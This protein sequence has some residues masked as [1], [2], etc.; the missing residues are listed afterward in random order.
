MTAAAPRRQ[1]ET[2]NAIAA[3]DEAATKVLMS[4]QRLA[5][6]A[7]LYDDHNQAQKM[8]LDATARAA[9][10]YAAAAGRNITIF[11]SDR[12]VYVGKRL[13]RANRSV[14]AAANQ[15]K[16]MLARMGVSQITIGHDVPIE[17]LRVLQSRFAQIQKTKGD[18][19][20]PTELSRVRLRVGR[21]PGDYAEFDRLSPDER[22]VKVYAL[23]IVIVRR[24]YEQLQRGQWEISSHVRRISE[25]LISLAEQATVG[26]LA[27][28]VCRP[29]HD[30]AERAVSAAILALAMG[31]QLTDDQR[32]LRWLATAAL[33]CDVGKPRVAGLNPDA[34]R[35]AGLRMPTLGL[36]QF[37]ELPGATAF[38]TTALGRLTDAGMMRSVLVYETLHIEYGEETGAIYGGERGPTMLSRLIACARRFQLGL[39]LG[40]A[41]GDVI[42]ALVNKSDGLVDRWIVQLMMGTLCVVPTGTIVELEDGRAARV[43]SPPTQRIDFGRPLVRILD[44]EGAFVDLNA[45]SRDGRAKPQIARILAASDED[46]ELRAAFDESAVAAPAVEEVK[47]EVLGV[48]EDD[49]L[50]WSLEDE[51]DAR[52]DAG[53]RDQLL[54]EGDEWIP[55]LEGPSPYPDDDLYE[56]FASDEAPVSSD[57]LISPFAQ[58][59]V[60]DLP[61]DSRPDAFAG[62]SAAIIRPL[63]RPL[64]QG[65][66]GKTPLM[67]LLI[68]ALDKK[69]TGT[70]LVV[71]ADRRQSAIRFEQGE[72]SK[73]KTAA[74]ISPLDRTIVAMG[75]LDDE[76]LD[77][78]LRRAHRR[79]RLH[80]QQL[81]QEGLLD[82]AALDA[83]L[84]QQMINKI[85][86]LMQLSP[87]TRFG[88]Y[89]DVDLLAD[90]GGVAATPCDPYPL[91]MMAARKY[92]SWEILDEVL[93]RVANVPLTLHEEATPER[94][95]LKKPERRAL[96]VL[97][98]EP[99][100]L[101]DLLLADGVDEEA[102]QR[103]IY[104]LV[105]T[106]SVT[107]GEGK[108]RP[109]GV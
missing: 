77:R 32:L 81:V 97:L 100:T 51:D 52:H 63:S 87:T 46:H 55:D 11:F 6:Q 75:L 69:L 2:G 102:A 79:G 17:E 71:E 42:A 76:T 15:M 105:V 31:H 107:L 33:L 73:V 28:T 84:Q 85:G 1:H 47:G 4:L 93:P 21:A 72:P 38:V 104:A 13:L 96:D 19:P 109:V 41:P 80:G 67:H 50:E 16:A 66:F 83:A 29:P 56:Q 64:A 18:V 70:L 58:P 88:Y 27:S 7:T 44:A 86:H 60:S 59:P 40:K 10:E 53:S 3:E 68:Y 106:R 49:E 12:A 22:A 98:R 23:A 36:D 101:N 37:A 82:A 61:P 24:F 74:L 14:Y 89:D 20:A 57:A 62:E 25:E 9:A 5:Q 92:V 48:D 91:I 26:Q 99:I 34:S 43:M 35:R 45:P 39:S 95:G 78:T 8:A 90:Y 103:L 65:A 30:D 54:A 108:K 94:L